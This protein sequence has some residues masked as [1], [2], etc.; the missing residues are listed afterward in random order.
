MNIPRALIWPTATF[1]TC[2]PDGMAAAEAWVWEVVG[3]EPSPPEPYLTEG[4]VMGDGHGRQ[5]R[6]DGWRWIADETPT[7]TEDN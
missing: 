7:T 1:N 3:I 4:R 5:W 6:Y 2:T